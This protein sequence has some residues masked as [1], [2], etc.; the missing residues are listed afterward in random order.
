[1]RV[2]L[3]NFTK[4]SDE[5]LLMILGWRNSPSV[6]KFM[7]DKH[8]SKQRHF[9]FVELL[10]SDK[11]REYFLVEQGGEYIGVISFVGI[12]KADCE[13]GVYANPDKKALAMC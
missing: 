7:Q 3:L 5:L 6:A 12:G 11:T 13:L 9:E 8:I 1:M 4:L 2:S 10:K